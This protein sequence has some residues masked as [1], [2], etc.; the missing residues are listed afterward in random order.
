MRSSKRSL[1]DMTSGGFSRRQMLAAL[2]GTAAAPL[3]P[4]FDVMAA[5][6]TYRLKPQR[7]TDG[8][9]MV[10]GAQEAITRENGGAIANVVILDTKAGAVV[11]DTGPSKRY[12]LSLASLARQLTGKDIAKV[13]LTHFH[14]DHV[15]GNQAFAPETIAAPQGVIQGLKEMGEGF[16]DAMYRTAGDWMR[17][18]ELV[19]PQTVVETGV[20]DFGDRRLRTLNMKGHTAS[21]MV[22]FDETS[23]F[24]FAGDLV[25][26]D[27]AP[28]TP[29]ADLEQWR[30]SLATLGAIPH[31]ALVPGHGPVEPG[32][33]GIQQTRDWLIA[34][35]EMI[36]AAFDKG[37]SITE[38]I[39]EPLP[40]W[41]ENIALAKYEYER[42][43]M[44][45]YPKLEAERLPRVDHSRG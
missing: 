36:K 42:S 26:L 10:A 1:P 2:A 27:R 9:W 11:I 21:D 14:P 35:D 29:N 30:I 17:G 23:G 3:L 8:V 34:V 12:G 25:F 13:Y 15:F 41:T 38:A 6:L 22:L 28:T 19:L 24:L 40:A 5:P 20:D 7:L 45:L 37:L 16:A 32:A 18:T 4:A 43:V 39:A 33:R 31:R 44:H